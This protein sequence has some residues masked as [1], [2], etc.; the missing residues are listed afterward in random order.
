[1]GPKAGA[2][3]GSLEVFT[4]NLPGVVDN[5]RRSPRDTFWVALSQSRHSR[6][7]SVL[8]RYGDDR[9][10]RASLMAVSNIR[11]VG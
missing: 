4:I 8:D 2:K 1:V 3:R 9:R 10:V 11:T 6:L 5:I 7:P